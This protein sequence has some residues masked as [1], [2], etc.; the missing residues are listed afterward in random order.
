MFICKFFWLLIKNW[1]LQRI[2][3]HVYEDDKIIEK[4]SYALGAQ[5][6]RD[7]IGRLYV[8]LNPWLKDGKLSPEMILEYNDKGDLDDK[9]YMEQWVMTRLN[10]ISRFIQANN[11]FDLLVYRID[12]L[13]D[14]NYL[15][16]VQPY[17]LESVLSTGKKSLIELLLWVMIAIG[18]FIFVL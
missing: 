5:F 4:M 3:N 11:L 7:W 16:V 9:M 1:K 12:E 13:R 2:L 6:R 14:N 10:I 8:V 15:L 18:L 17:T